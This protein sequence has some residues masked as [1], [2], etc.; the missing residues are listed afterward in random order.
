MAKPNLAGIIIRVSGVRVPPPALFMNPAIR[1]PYVRSSR[2][3]VRPPL[4]FVSMKE[5]GL[6]MGLVGRGHGLG[7]VGGVCAST[8]P[9]HVVIVRRLEAH[10]LASAYSTPSA[11]SRT[12]R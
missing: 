4:L 1:R 3:G 12:R 6:S 10:E 2:V 7:W 11:C 5:D 9:A 8:S